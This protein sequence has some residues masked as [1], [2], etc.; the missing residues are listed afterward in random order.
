MMFRIPPLLCVAIVLVVVGCRSD[1]DSKAAET[2]TDSA[3]EVE[4]NSDW[5]E[6]GDDDDDDGDDDDD[7]VD[8]DEKDDDTGKVEYPACGDDVETGAPCEGGW[9]ETICLDEDDML[10]WCDA[11]KWTADKNG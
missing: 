9:E 10:W 7:D 6:L 4:P 3:P 2:E 8:D 11:G 5:E 1:A